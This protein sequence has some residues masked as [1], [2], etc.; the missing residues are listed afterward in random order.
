MLVVVRKDF[1]RARATPEQRQ[2]LKQQ[3]G[4]LGFFPPMREPAG[5]ALSTVTLG[6]LIAS[7]VGLLA[8]WA[9]A[10]GLNLVAVVGML[11][12]S[13]RNLDWIHAQP[14]YQALG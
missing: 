6:L 7:V 5:V 11:W 9:A 13:R 8:G 2:W 3:G 4:R 10:S 12:I 1:R 14:D